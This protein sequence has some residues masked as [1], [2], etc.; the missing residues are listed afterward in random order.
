MDG[1][2]GGQTEIEKIITGGRVCASLQRGV[3]GFG[4]GSNGGRRK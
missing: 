4:G 1:T 2:T 3:L